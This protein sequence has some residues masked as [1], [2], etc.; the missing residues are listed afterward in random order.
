M[1]EK[2]VSSLP[3]LCQNHVN[4]C[5][6]Q[7]P[8]IE[9]MEKH[10]QGCHLA[11]REIRCPNNACKILHIMQNKMVEHFK[12]DHPIVKSIVNDLGKFED[13]L[14]LAEDENKIV[15]FKF[16]DD[17]FYFVIRLDQSLWRMY[18][19]FVGSPQTAKKFKCQIKIISTANDCS[20]YY[21]SVG[22]V[23]APNPGLPFWTDLPSGLVVN[24]TMMMELAIGDRF[25]QFC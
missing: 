23:F 8:K 10:E 3:F 25:C 24:K 19:Y 15:H 20:K 13:V 4:G 2:L 22:D 17:N 14:D 12:S 16:L 7:E 18:I 9:S 1:A 21:N 5:T 6:V 11:L